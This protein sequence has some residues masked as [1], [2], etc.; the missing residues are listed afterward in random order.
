MTAVIEKDITEQAGS[1][2]IQEIWN[3]GHDECQSGLSSTDGQIIAFEAG[4][5]C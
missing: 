2:I 1:G 5:Q 4:D 3:D